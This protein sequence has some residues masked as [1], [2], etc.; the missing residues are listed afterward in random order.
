M[1]GRLIIMPGSNGGISFPNNSFGGSGDTATITLENPN[2]GEATEMTFT[3]T[4]DGNDIFNF[5]VPDNNGMKVNRNTVWHAGNDGAGSGL[6][7]DKLQGKSPNDFA[8]SGF[9]LGGPAKDVGGCNLNTL[10]KTGFYKGCNMSN[11]PTNGWYYI[12]VISHED[13]WS[14]QYLCGYGSGSTNNAPTYLYKRNLRSNVW[15]NWDTIYTSNN[16]P[17]PSDLGASANGHTHDDR[18]YTESESDAKYATKDQIS[19]AGYGDMLK[20][21]YDTNNN[22][23][24]DNSDKLDGLHSESFFRTFSQGKNYQG[25]IGGGQDLGWKKLFRMTGYD[26]SGNGSATS[27][28]NCYDAGTIMGYIYNRNGNF[29]QNRTDKYQFQFTV[30]TWAGTSRQDST[31]LYIPSGMPDIIRVVKY[32]VNDY[33]LQIRTYSDWRTIQFE[34]FEVGN[35]GLSTYSYQNLTSYTGTGTVVKT[36]SNKDKIQHE[37][38]TWN[39]VKGV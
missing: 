39:D 38:L 17:T 15:D 4:N 20:S 2:G 22:G 9:G 11:A 24:V 6:D 27:L 28:S 12:I 35:N 23:V 19:K 31:N 30:C 29:N 16:K 7:A 36:A 18:Y 26:R 10:Q 34:L 1:N 13:S 8:P 21:V 37:P 5:K 14:V 3:I 32:A 25:S 33:E